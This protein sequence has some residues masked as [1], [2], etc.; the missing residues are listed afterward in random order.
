[1]GG[2]GG[3]RGTIHVIYAS[4]CSV[5]FLTLFLPLAHHRMPFSSPVISF[6]ILTEISIVGHLYGGENVLCGANFLCETKVLIV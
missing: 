2:R 4:V 1:M 5:Y 6:E 3:E